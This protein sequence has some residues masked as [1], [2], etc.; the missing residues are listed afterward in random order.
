MTFWF[1]CC[2]TIFLSD[3]LEENYGN[4]KN[5][6]KMAR[7]GSVFEWL[8]TNA[9]MDFSSAVRI[10]ELY[11]I[12]DTIALSEHYSY[13]RIMFCEYADTFILYNIVWKSDEKG[14][15][16]AFSRKKDFQNPSKNK[17]FR[18]YL[19]V[20]YIT[21]KKIFQNAS[22]SKNQSKLASVTQ[23]YDQRS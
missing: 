17:D 14:R 7:L 13:S 10:S 16:L 15:Y 4:F 19:S 8:W 9:L 11:S 12:F 5:V 6:E 1:F 2:F 20:P 18:I 21:L 22:L 23:T 3:R